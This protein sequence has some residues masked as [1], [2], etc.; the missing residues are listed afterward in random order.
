MRVF[1]R[2]AAV[3]AALFVCLPLAAQPYHVELEAN[4]AAAFPYLSMFGKV[5][6]HVYQ[7]GVRTDALW[8]NAF[9]KNG[10]SAV[11]VA[12]PL[13]RTYAEIPVGEIAPLLAKLAGAA[14][15]I[16]R[17][18]ATPIRKPPVAGTVAG[19]KAT[20]HRLMYGPEA[21][22]DYWT[23]DVVPENPQLRE[24]VDQ[25]VAGISPPTVAPTRQ[26][27]GM[28]VYIEL[29]FRRFRK[30]PLLQL[31]KLTFAADDE[32]DALEL[33]PFYVRTGAFEKVLGAD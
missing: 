15:A 3:A 10:A 4:P 8:L 19:I 18:A 24:I 26:V 21:W 6:I 32:E 33:G 5:D 22:I 29:N 13:G 14:G 30:V 1:I 17:N 25:L 16:E 28:P 20:R 27:T 23:T 31:K 2:R 7:S 9:S 12:N 11:T